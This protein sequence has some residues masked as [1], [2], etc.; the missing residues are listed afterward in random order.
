M[1]KA[2]ILIIE[3][4][5]IISDDIAETLKECQYSVAGIAENVDEALEILNNQKVDLILLDINLN[6]TV[7]G[8]QIAHIINSDYQL[9]FIFVTAFTDTTTIER[10]KHTKPFGYITKPYNDIDL[11]IAIDLA[12]SK[13]NLESQKSITK[14]TNTDEPIFV[15]TKKGLEKIKLGDIRW[16]E[17]YDYYSFIRLKKDKILVTTTLKDLEQ[18]IN[19]ASF[20]KVHRKYT[21]NF[22]HIEKVVGN[23]IEIEGELIPVSRSHKEGLLNRLNLI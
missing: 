12:L 1:N 18:K 17:A 15:K 8:I 22:N 13:F 14:P 2:N 10:V 6:E 3:D 20:I 7:D 5:F 16:I 4:E 9:P 21:V 11:M 19:N 23:Q